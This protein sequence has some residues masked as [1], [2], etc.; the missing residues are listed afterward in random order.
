MVAGSMLGE[1]ASMVAGSMSG[2]EAWRG[3]MAAFSSR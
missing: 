3:L 2:E 1:E